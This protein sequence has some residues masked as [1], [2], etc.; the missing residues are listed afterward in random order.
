[1]HD[2]ISFLCNICSFS[3]ISIFF[4]NRAVI[5]SKSHTDVAGALVTS[6]ALAGRLL[7]CDL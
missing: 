3:F 2:H 1:L 4:T 5:I 7:H 6:G